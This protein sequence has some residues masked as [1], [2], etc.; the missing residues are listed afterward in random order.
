MPSILHKYFILAMSLLAFAGT[1]LTYV[2]TFNFCCGLLCPWYFIFCGLEILLPILLIVT[3]V[4]LIKKRTG[5]NLISVLLIVASLLVFFVLPSS[6]QT[7]DQRFEAN[8]ARYEKA[9]I[10]VVANIP[11]YQEGVQYFE[12]E[13]LP[14]EYHGLSKCRSPI[15]IDEQD[16]FTQ[17]FFV[18]STDWYSVSGYLYSS[19]DRLHNSDFIFSVELED[20]CNKIEEH[21][22]FCDYDD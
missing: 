13:K 16:S 17:A 11:P 7:V 20:V 22:Y 3:L 14:D 9:I 1:L 21:W 4:Q 8:R 12:E 15:A 5:S 18:D 6:S 19:D 2:W 10:F